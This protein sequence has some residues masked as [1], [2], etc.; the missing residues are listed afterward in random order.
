MRGRRTREYDWE[1]RAPKKID[2]LPLIRTLVLT[3]PA[4]KVNILLTRLVL[5][6]NRNGDAKS[7]MRHDAGRMVSGNRWRNH[8]VEV[9][10]K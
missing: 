4:G 9:R 8:R 5:Q 10:A 1:H 2:G 6:F 3:G 7:G